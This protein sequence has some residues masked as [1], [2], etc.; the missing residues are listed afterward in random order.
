MFS[1]FISRLYSHKMQ[2]WNPESLINLELQNTTEDRFAVVVLNRRISV[3]VEV[4]TNLWQNAAIRCLVDGGANRWHQFLVNNNL[5]NSELK[6]PDFITGD[7]DSILEET[8]TYFK[9][10]SPESIKIVNTPDQNETD[11][12]KS[13]RVLKS[14]LDRLNVRN[15]IVFQEFSGRLD[16]MMGNINTL[17]KCESILLENS[18]VFLLSSSSMT[19]LLKPGQHS[20]EI[21]RDLVEN[22]RWCSLLPIG[23]KAI[24]TTDGLKWDLCEF[25]ILFF[26]NFKYMYFFQIMVV[27]NLEEW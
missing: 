16:Q 5:S 3:P 21:P 10:N 2:K 9:E 26:F 24:V 1:S 17:Y 8:M 23:E 25:L 14:N 19:W 15:V 11:F 18:R 13:L 12:T 4:T 22:K 20:I 6:S 7:F 27:Y